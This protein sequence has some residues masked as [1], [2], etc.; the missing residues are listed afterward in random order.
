MRWKDLYKIGITGSRKFPNCD[1]VTEWLTKYI[2]VN[3]E[4]P[5]K[6]VLVTGGSIG[7][8]NA[9]ETM[10]IRLGLKNLMLPARWLSFDRAAG[11][12]RNEYIVDLSNE[13]LAFWAGPGVDSPG[14]LGTIELMKKSNKYYQV[15]QPKIM[16][17]DL[18]YRP[19]YIKLPPKVKTRDAHNIRKLIKEAKLGSYFKE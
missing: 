1:L 11:M 17:K 2:S 9:V 19:S 4:D 8:D 5:D 13:M 12:I 6:I 10:C 3:F 16:M 7:V 15:L 14:T 18:G